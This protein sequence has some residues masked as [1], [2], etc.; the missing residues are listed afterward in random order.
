MAPGDVYRAFLP[1]Y[2]Q[3]VRT[4]YGHSYVELDAASQTKALD[5]LR[6]G[7]AVIPLA[8]STAFTSVDFYNLFRQNVLEGMLADPAY[9]GNRGM[10][11]WKWIGFP[12]DPMRR[13]DVYYKYVFTDKPYPYEN[14]PLP[15]KPYK[16]GN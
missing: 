7:K 10:V 11:G 16:G 8:G 1:G 14:K 3:Y 9:G 13:G 6:T 15:M 5:D 4:T 2:D 12:G